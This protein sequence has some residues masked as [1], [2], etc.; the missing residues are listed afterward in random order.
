MAKTFQIDPAH[1][2]I[3]FSVRHMMIS[4]VRGHFAEFTGQAQVEGDDLT[5]AVAEATI[6]TASVNTGVNDRDNH[7]RS[8]D[9]FEAEQHPELKFKSTSIER[10]GDGRYLVRGDLTMRGTTRPIELE[11]TVEGPI[12]DPYG[13]ERVAVEARGRIKRT[14]WGLNYNA[15]LE[16]G[17][18]IVSDDIRL[19]IEAELVAAKET[20]TA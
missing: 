8:A 19:E 15:L 17:G 14:E 20:A 18:A 1:T 4:T 11:A 2:R 3:G 5:T 9:F 16:T 13:F 7:L 6:K 12:T 10:I